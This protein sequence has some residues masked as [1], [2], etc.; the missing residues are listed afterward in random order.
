[1]RVQRANRRTALMASYSA[2]AV[3]APSPQIVPATTATKAETSPRKGRS[4]K[5]SIQPRIDVSKTARARN[6]TATAKPVSK[7]RLRPSGKIAKS[8]VPPPARAALPQLVP[9]E[10]ESAGDVVEAILSVSGDSDTPLA[11]VLVMR[12]ETAAETTTTAVSEMRADAGVP[13]G[14]P[15]AAENE[16][17]A[18]NEIIPASVR[19]APSPTFLQALAVQWAGLL[20]ILIQTWNWSRRKL[21]SHQ[22][23]KRLRVCETI[24]LGEKRFVAVIQVDGEQFLVGGSSSS[25]STLAH[26]ERRQEF[27]DVFKSRC[28]QD[29]SQA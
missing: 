12:E 13:S 9:P 14:A 17:I 18:K 27:S 3:A 22:V 24:S 28:E 8:K 5:T 23:R 20:R 25:V 15:E 26:L 29:L 1:M 16:V 6:R 7:A 10:R 2:D 21:K 4:G 19:D 11:P